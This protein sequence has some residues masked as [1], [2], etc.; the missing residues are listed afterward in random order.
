MWHHNPKVHHCVHKSLPLVPILSQWNPLPSQPISLRSI[1]IPSSH[2]SG[3]FPSG[4][5][6]KTL[7]HFS[8]LSHT[9]KMPHPTHLFT[10][11]IFIT[12]HSFKIKGKIFSYKFHTTFCLKG[13]RNR[14]KLFL[15]WKHYGV[16]MYDASIFE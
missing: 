6:T 14:K 9:C 1:L 3:L 7:V 12:L 15:I 10:H 8:L 4:F 11:A 13:F 16:C 5:P 2:L